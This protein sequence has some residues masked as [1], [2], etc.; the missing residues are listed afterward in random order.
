MWPR[1]VGRPS[2]PV[3][4]PADVGDADLGP[5][6]VLGQPVD[7]GEQLGSGEGTHPPRII[8]ARGDAPS[9]PTTR[10]SPR[11]GPPCRRPRP[12][13]TSTRPS[14][15]PIPAEVHRAMAELADWELAV[16]RRLRG[17]STRGPPADGRGASGRGGGGGG[18]SRARSPS[19]TRAR[20]PGRGGPASSTG[21]RAIGRHGRRRRVSADGPDRRPPG[22]ARASSLGTVDGPAGRGRRPD[23]RRRSRRRLVPGTRLVWLSHVAGRQRDRPAGRPDRGARPTPGAPSWRSTGR[24]RSGRSRSTSGVSARTSTRSRPRRGCSV[25]TGSGRSTSARRCSTGRV[26]FPADVRRRGVGPSVGG[27]RDPR[28]VARRPGRASRP[29]V[30]GFARS[31]AWL[32]MYVGWAWI[33]GGRPG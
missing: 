21:D 26:D 8:G 13:S 25:P 31:V 3:R 1:R 33:H 14:R 18:R 20:R 32:S 9:C 12:G 15:G 30:T 19:S 16:G 28:L 27:G 7:A 17:P 24:R 22:A 23:R 4:P 11:S 29:S 5:A 10:S 2:G 6:E